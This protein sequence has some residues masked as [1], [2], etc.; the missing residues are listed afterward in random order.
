MPIFKATTGTD[1]FTTNN[2]GNDTFNF[3]AGTAQSTDVIDGGAGNDTLTFTGTSGSIDFSVISISN[4]ENLTAV[5]NNNNQTITV[6]AAQFAGFTSINMSGNNDSDVLNVTVNGTVD[7]S[8]G[9]TPSISNTE[10]VRLVDASGGSDSIKLTG[11]Q[12]NLFTSIAFTGGGSDTINLTSTSTGL[13][14][15][16]DSNLTGAET[17]S[18]ST[19]AAAVT[20][21]LAKQTE[22][23]TVNA[24]DK[25]DTITGGAGNDAIT[26]GAGNDVLAGG[27]GNDTITGGA[28]N[29]TITGGAGT[30]ILTG[31][32]GADTFV[33]SAASDFTASETINGTA[34]QSTLDTLRLDAAGTYSLTSTVTNIDVIT[35]NRNA[36]GFNLTVTDSQA[37][38]ADANQDG[39]LNDLLIKSSASMTNGVTINASGL[40]GTNHITVDGT[41]LGGN[42]TISG[43]QRRFGGRLGHDT[44]GAGDDTITG[45]AG[46]D[47]LTG[48]LGADTFVMS[49]ASGFTASE[50]INGTA[51]QSTLD[52]LRL[53][54]AGT[55][56]LTSTVTNI[57][58]ITLNRNASGF[59]LTVTNSQAGSADANQ[60]GTL[61]DLLIKSSASMTNGVTINASGLTGT[62]HITVDGTNLGGDDTITGGAGNDVLAGGS[63]ND[64]IT[65]G[66]GT[67]ILTG[68]LGADTFVMSAASDFTASETING[69][70][71]QSTLDT[72]RLDAAGTYSLTSTVTNIDVI[73]LNR[74]APGF[75][76][77][78]T[79]SQAGSADANQDGTLND[80]L[81]KS[82]A[83]MTNGVTINA[84]GLTGTNHITVDGTNLGGNDTMAAD[85]IRGGRQRQWRGAGDDT[86]TGGAGSDILTGGLGADTFVMSAA[87][88]FTASET[89]N[90]TAEQSTLDTL[91]LDA[92]G[93]YSLTSTVTNIDVITLNRN[94]SGFNLTVT[95]SQAG[96]ADANQD[97]TLNDLLI[98]SSASM[99]NG[100]TINASGLTGTNHI[101]VDGT[102]LGGDDTI[103]GGAGN[104]VLAGGSGND[105]ITGGAGNDTIDGGIG[106]DTVVYS[107][108]W[109]DYTVS[110]TGPFTL[111]DNRVNS[112]D[113]TDTVS[114]V[115]NFQFSNVTATTAQLL[116]DAPT[117]IAL[118]TSTVAENSANGT[119]IGSLSD[120]DPDSVLGDTARYTLTND[121]GGRFAISGT[122]L[123]VANGSLLDYESATSHNVTVQVADAHGATFSKTFT[124]AVSDQ[125]DTA[126]VITSAA[127]FSVAENTTAVG[128]VTEEERLA[129]P[130]RSRS[131]A[132]RM[133]R[134]S[135]STPTAG[136]C[137][138]RRRATMRPRRT[139]M[140]CR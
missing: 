103:S 98:K 58:V 27:S 106:T 137:R 10:T 29:D 80:L 31:G 77:T 11:A 13:N 66:A 82:S 127:T 76:L 6:S 111:T 69:T 30:D 102:N 87:S 140:R 81:I 9:T 57:D 56:S 114:N 79:D 88:D 72:L 85:T 133:P 59:N 40:T 109:V 75:N 53:D 115:E 20:I 120:T 116:N 71:E 15:L 105:T 125:N 104:D 55:Y 38:S 35:L 78:V 65:G 25:G 128:T 33:M 23:F 70:A 60:D 63:G 131:A 28:G 83:S 89:I 91:R 74:N 113:G 49:A 4:I 3:A 34:E 130:S 45:G 26:G 50:T 47:I 52:T 86:I 97:G 61:N 17:I 139:A 43:R 2:N 44:K 101:T 18:A 22:G 19:A 117:N 94:A 96:S 123:V 134:C 14:A 62:N 121:A 122:N 51:E 5:G 124:I 41:N 107:G 92:A 48:G 84:S 138:S 110:G 118:S 135:R 24:S 7:I 129:A 8:G 54:A 37:G 95:D 90:G 108:A 21:N 64:T 136:R 1:N 39:T 42:D 99:T 46:S 68:G 32:L 132:G 12:L 100:V 67:D 119:I 16:S 36:P 73:T 93:T 112:P 126:P